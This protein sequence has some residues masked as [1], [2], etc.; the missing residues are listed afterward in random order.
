MTSNK[1]LGLQLIDQFDDDSMVDGNK[2]LC[3]RQSLLMC[4]KSMLQIELT[5]ID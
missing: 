2:F 3:K 5:N 4:V 1:F